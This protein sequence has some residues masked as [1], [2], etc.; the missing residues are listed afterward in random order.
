[1]A[2]PR[3]TTA[4]I[5][6]GPVGLATALMAAR[7][8]KSLVISRPRPNCARAFR[9]DSV[10]APLLA[11]LVE[12]GL[13]PARLGMEEI[14]HHRLIAWE[15]AEPRIVPSAATVHLMRPLLEEALLE[16]VRRHVNI[17]LEEQRFSALAPPSNLCLDATGR[18]SVS[19]THRIIPNNPAMCRV[20][21][22]RGAFSKAQ[23]AFRIAAT[24]TGYVYRSGVASAMVLGVVQ[25]RREWAAPIRDLARYLRAAGADWLV[26][27]LDAGSFRRAMGGAAC[28]Q[29][30]VGPDS[31]IRIGDAALARDPLSSQGISN[32]ISDGL[33][34]CNAGAEAKN[35]YGEF[36]GHIGNLRKTISAC[37]YADSPY[38][39][40][41]ISALDDFERRIASL[42]A[43]LCGRSH[44]QGDSNEHR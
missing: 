24:P 15:G 13:H 34:A 4:I 19:A 29:W 12:L 44:A 39:S 11:L 2:Y 26:A 37:R 28:I 7:R 20:Y 27:G 22:L 30:N 38:W 9:I 10:P 23:Q 14:Q 16:L 18:A 40:G 25:G 41:Y 31:P 42:D 1:M 8:G 3:W 5:G 43:A 32:G 6:A 35:R 21:A 36:R 33:K 17:T